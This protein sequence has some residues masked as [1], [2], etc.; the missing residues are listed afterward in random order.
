[1]KVKTKDLIQ[2]QKESL[3]I[4]TN[5]ISPKRFFDISKNLFLHNFY[6]IFLDN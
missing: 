6:T 5:N 4:K 3:I 1:M 2:F